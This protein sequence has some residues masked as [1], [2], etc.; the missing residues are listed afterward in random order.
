M[1]LA[2]HCD[3]GWVV[4]APSLGFLKGNQGIRRRV[5]PVTVETHRKHKGH[6]LPLFLSGL[7]QPSLGYAWE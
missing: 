2:P 3:L 5:P 1:K 4:L 7:S 6:L